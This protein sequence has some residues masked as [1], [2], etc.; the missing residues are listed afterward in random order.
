MVVFGQLCCLDREGV[1]VV[2]VC[3]PSEEAH[4]EVRP[5]LELQLRSQ[6]ERVLERLRPLPLAVFL[7]IVIAHD[8]TLVP[9]EEV[10]PSL[11]RRCECALSQGIGRSV[12]RN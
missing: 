10:A 2:R 4:E 9:L 5:V 3:C 1:E 8:H 7:A 12:A 11:L 6:T